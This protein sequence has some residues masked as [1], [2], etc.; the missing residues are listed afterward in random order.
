[1]LVRDDYGGYTSY[2]TDLTG[3]Q[4]CL[5]HVLRY[6]DDA[7]AINTDAQAWARQVADALRAAIHEINT[8]RAEDQA[9]PDADLITRLRRRYDNGRG[10]RDLHEP[11]P[12][13]AQ[14]QPSR[15]ATGPTAQAQSRAGVAVH[16]PTRR[17]APRTTGRSR[18]SAASSSPPRS[19]AAGAP[20][21]PCNGTAGSGPTSS[22]PATTDA[23]PIDAIR[24]ALTANPWMP[25]QTA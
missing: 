5:S 19:K 24:D 23:D 13:L 8:T 18:R 22:A 15:P 21:P 17:P 1:M 4:Q 11:V 16:H 14:G 6:L 2:D 12:A 3:V 20:W 25:P 9:T 10:R 7:H